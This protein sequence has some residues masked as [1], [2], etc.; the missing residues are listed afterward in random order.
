MMPNLVR[1]VLIDLLSH[2]NI[3]SKAATI[4]HLRSRSAGRDVG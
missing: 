4:R 3:A 2:P 1:Q